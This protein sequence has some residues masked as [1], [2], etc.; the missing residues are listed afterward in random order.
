MH[1]LGGHI[2]PDQDPGSLARCSV[3]AITRSYLVVGGYAPL[4]TTR[5]M[6]IVARSDN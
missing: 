5:R 2:P 6:V 1:S 3:I 4:I